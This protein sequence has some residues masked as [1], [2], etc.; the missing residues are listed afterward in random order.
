MRCTKSLKWSFVNFASTGPPG[1]SHAFGVFHYKSFYYKYFFV[2]VLN[3]ISK[4]VV[5]EPFQPEYR[6]ETTTSLE[7]FRY[8]DLYYMFFFLKKIFE[9]FAC[10]LF[11]PEHP[12]E[13]ATP[14]FLSLQKYNIRLLFFSRVQMKFSPN[15]TVF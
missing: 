1:N 14:S 4:V 10:K 15:Q 3:E 6:Q 7:V 5:S 9:V 8:K 2:F 12:L 13:T 11:Q